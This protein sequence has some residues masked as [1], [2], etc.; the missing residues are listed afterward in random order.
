L[1]Y[2]LMPASTLLPDTAELRLDHLLSEPQSM[3]M[4]VAAARPTACCPVCQ[5]PSARVH[6]RYIR[7]LADL[8]WSGTTVRLR[9][10]TRRFF[11]SS[12][13][14]SR[15]IFTERLPKTAARYARRTTRLNE[16]LQLMGLALGGEA[17]ARLAARLGMGVS[18]DTL[19][20]RIRQLTAA[21]LPTPR[22]L[23]VDDWAWKKGHRYGTI[24]VDL[25][26]HRV[27]DLLPDRQA[28]T[29]ASWLQQHPGVEVISRD[30]AGAY[31]D[32][33]RRGA[34]QARQVADRWHLLANLGECVREWLERHRPLLQQAMPPALTRKPEP[35][36]PVGSVL[37]K[38][39]GE[40]RWQRLAEQR[41]ARRLARYQ[42]VRQLRQQGNSERTIARQL[43]ISRKVVRRFLAAPVFPE[44]AAR[45]PRATLLT[46]YHE[47]LRRRWTEGCRN[48]AQLLREI[49]QQGYRGKR[50]AV[51]DFVAKWRRTEN[52]PPGF[53]F[54]KPSIRNSFAPLGSSAPVTASREAY[55]C[56]A[57]LCRSPDPVRRSRC[58]GRTG[59]TILADC[60]GAPARGTRPMDRAGREN[61]STGTAAVR[62]GAETRL[63]RG[64]GSA[65][66]AL[67]Q[68]A[69]GRASAS[70]E[71]HQA[72]NVRARQARPAA[73][74]AT[75]GGLRTTS[76]SL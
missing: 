18:G 68:W 49:S 67:E 52:P 37:P 22:V 27:V 33:A 53:T 17:G 69:C 41:R 75:T 63:C 71:A 5:H 6:S 19:L 45:P 76:I 65:G 9:L 10:H 16:A 35:T 42:Q 66:R 43:R 50:S 15:R 40:D 13:T 58:G 51:N 38:Q 54:G 34:P 26:R 70:A 11:C 60:P 72:A 47:Y 24:L 32:G 12:L 55:E 57:E 56:A 4:V 31:A 30:R 64:A 29:L 62:G 48:A 46:P 25:E 39:K 44:R 36:V 8:P 7:S 1:V 61:Y 20:R 28:E 73:S 59:A 23:G 74:A 14:C 21:D 3:T 2:S